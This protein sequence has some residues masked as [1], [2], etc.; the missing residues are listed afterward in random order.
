[1]LLKSLLFRLGLHVSLSL[2][3]EQVFHFEVFA[4]WKFDV[5]NVWEAWKDPQDP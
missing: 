5:F 2:I 3:I 1:M 4:S